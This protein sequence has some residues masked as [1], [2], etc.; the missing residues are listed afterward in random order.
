LRSD[1]ATARRSA[2]AWHRGRPYH[3]SRGRASGWFSLIQTANAAQG[4][5]SSSGFR[6]R[7]LL[8]DTS[9]GAASPAQLTT[10]RCKRGYEAFPRKTLSGPALAHELRSHPRGCETFPRK[11]SP[12][13]RSAR[14]SCSHPRGCE[15]PDNDPKPCAASAVWIKEIHPDARRLQRWYG[16]PRCHVPRRA[17]GRR[18]R[19]EAVDVHVASGGGDCHSDVE[20]VSS[21][22]RARRSR[23]CRQ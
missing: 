6:N 22:E 20:S 4:F 16:L 21:D 1:I 3:L 11:R 19:S 5:R 17:L 15:T 10:R 14:E 2:G 18:N 13:R 23:H 12:F 9:S 7:Q 8:G